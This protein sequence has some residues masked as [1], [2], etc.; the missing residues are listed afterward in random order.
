MKKSNIVFAAVAAAIMIAMCF[1]AYYISSNEVTVSYSGTS[2]ADVDNSYTITDFSASYDVSEN[3]V[4]SAHEKI[5]VIFNRFGKR[6]IIRY[7]PLNSGEKYRGFKVTAAENQPS[8]WKNV[9]H[10]SDSVVEVDLGYEDES[11]VTY[12]S[13]TPITFDIE[14]ELIMPKAYSGDRFYFNLSG[15]G[16]NTDIGSFSAAVSLPCGSVSD[17]E[18]FSGATGNSGNSL[19]ADCAVLNKDGKTVIGVNCNN[20]P[21]FNG[22]TLRTLL[23][24]GTL[25]PYNDIVPTVTLIAAVGLVL[26]S[27][28]VAFIIKDRSVVIPVTNFYPPKWNGKELSPFEMGI[29]IDGNCD[30]EDVTSLVFYWASK[31]LISIEAPDSDSP[32]LIKNRD[33]STDEPYNS[34]EK[35]LFDTIFQNGDRTDLNGL[36]NRIYR[37]VDLLKANGA[38]EIKKQMYKS[39]FVSILLTGIISAVWSIYIAA[40]SIVAGFD[41]WGGKAIIGIAIAMIVAIVSYEFKKYEFKY[42]G[43]K[44]FIYNLILFTASAFACTVYGLACLNTDIIGSFGIAAAPA[45]FA[46]CGFVFGKTV[47]R[48][49]KYTE[50]LGEIVGFREFLKTAE[51]DRIETMLADDPDYYYNILPYAQVLGITE[52]WNKKFRDITISP[53][54]YIYGW[55]NPYSF[56]YY[57]SVIR[58]FGST[59]GT[60]AASRPSTAVKS[61]GGIGG[62]FGGSGFGGGGFGGGGG[63]SGGGFGGGG[64]GSR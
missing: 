22:I 61:G 64:G 1:A 59:F 35:A 36:N 55:S 39:N 47:H 26:I 12:P 58:S 37:K 32:V 24:E 46:V 16:W 2:A 51:K 6:G 30:N 41:D 50:I 43:I 14:Y 10:Y 34:Y 27:I 28:A 25:T 33:I 62:R 15:Q 7:L 18:I 44:K 49:P 9:Y 20:L 29:L 4:V 31:G 40:T 11:E 52:L 57:N 21:P 19:D 54:S 3:S 8:E 56:L 17:T 38:S 13:D 42:S 5:T 53:P 23:P 48:R 45:V 63:F 60:V